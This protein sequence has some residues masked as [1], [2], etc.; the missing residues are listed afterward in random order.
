MLNT[1]SIAMPRELTTT[2]KATSWSSFPV[3]AKD[4]DWMLNGHRELQDRND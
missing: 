4:G 1:T 3:S 2:Q